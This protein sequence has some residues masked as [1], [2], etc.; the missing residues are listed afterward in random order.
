[1]TQALPP[2]MEKGLI[3]LQLARPDLWQTNPTI[4]LLA[5]LFFVFAILYAPRQPRLT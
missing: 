2:Y 4:L 3:G 1:M 5:I